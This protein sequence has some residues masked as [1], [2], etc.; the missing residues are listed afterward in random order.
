MNSSNISS[1]SVTEQSRLA[2]GTLAKPQVQLILSGKRKCGKDFL[3]HLIFN[4]FS[5]KILSFRISGPIKAAFANKHGLNLTELLGASQYKEQYRKKMVQWSEQVRQTDPHYFLRLAIL[6]AYE[7]GGDKPIWLL[8]DARRPTDLQYFNDSSEID[9]SKTRVVKLRIVST[10]QTR[11]K[12]GWIFTEG[13]DDQT[14]ECGLDHITDWD[15]IIEN[16]GTKEELLVKMESIF[17]FI[18]K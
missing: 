7:A 6:E 8:N 1:I 3:E 17:Q 13:I 4:R 16:N 12:R 15:Y 14:T 2:I 9:M 18:N 10:E 5:N 11:M